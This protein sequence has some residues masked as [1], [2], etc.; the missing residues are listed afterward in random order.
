[1]F[2][3]FLCIAWPII[4]LLTFLAYKLTKKKYRS[5]TVIIITGLTF[6]I[7]VFVVS[8]AF[9]MSYSMRLYDIQYFFIYPR[10]FLFSS[11][12]VQ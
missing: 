2:N 11:G 6:V 3:I 7:S 5:T 1:M 4:I 9:A 8:N 10:F 12:I